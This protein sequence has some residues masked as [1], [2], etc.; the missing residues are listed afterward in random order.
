[1]AEKC[2]APDQCFSCGSQMVIVNQSGIRQCQNRCPGAVWDPLYGWD[3]AV[4]QAKV[5][6]EIAR[7]HWSVPRE[8]WVRW[9]ESH[10]L[11]P[12]ADYLGYGLRQTMTI[13]KKGEALGVT[14]T[15]GKLHVSS[16][17]YACVGAI[18]D[19]RFYRFVL[20]RGTESVVTTVCS[21][22]ITSGFVASRT[23]IRGGKRS[24][25]IE[26]KAED[27]FSGLMF[28]VVCFNGSGDVIAPPTLD[29]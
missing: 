18:G 13:V 21:G 11:Q 20:P 2:S 23:D 25:H 27:S 16:H 26:A 5:E 4:K 7:E 14:Y 6:A 19:D 24:R 15:D 3:P 8:P 28:G 17:G 9:R 12:V 1:M 22:V 10:P 29:L